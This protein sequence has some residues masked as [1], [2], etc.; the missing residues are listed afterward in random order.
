MSS[1]RSS[2]SVRSSTQKILDEKRE[3]YGELIERAE[4]LKGRKNKKE[5]PIS[6]S[7]IEAGI[8]MRTC[9][10]ID[11]ARRHG[12]ITNYKAT[13]R[14]NHLAIQMEFHSVAGAAYF[15]GRLPAVHLV[16]R[17]EEV[18]IGQEFDEAL[19]DEIQKRFHW[20][21]TAEAAHGE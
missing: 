21:E 15:A 20:I 16:H 2:P 13:R 3:A 18:I 7:E 17:G 5:G 9:E 14:K 12:L 6:R 19:L 11:S 1:I 4:E 8:L 10:L